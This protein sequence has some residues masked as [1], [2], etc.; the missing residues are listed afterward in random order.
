MVL[1]LSGL[2]VAALSVPFSQYGLVNI[3][4]RVQVGLYVFTK[5]PVEGMAFLTLLQY[6][7]WIPV[8]TAAVVFFPGDDFLPRLLRRCGAVVNLAALGYLFKAFPELLSPERVPLLLTGTALLFLCNAALL[9][10]MPRKKGGKGDR[11]LSFFL[12]WLMGGGS[13]AIFLYAA[14]KQTAAPAAWSVMAGCAL[15]L[16]AAFFCMIR[17]MQKTGPK[18]RG[19]SQMFLLL[20]LLVLGVFIAVSPPLALPVAAGLLLCLAVSMA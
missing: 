16:L 7:V 3:P 13:I 15:A 17:S 11:A 5:M 6:F 10:F 14:A 8:A 2:A 1:S 4:S 9:F 18:G 19:N 20:P 12:L